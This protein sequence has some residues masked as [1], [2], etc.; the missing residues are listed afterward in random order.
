MSKRDLY[1]GYQEKYMTGNEIKEFLSVAYGT[2]GR[3]HER[4]SSKK[5]MSIVLVK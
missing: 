2:F 4:I 5:L 1:N 3:H